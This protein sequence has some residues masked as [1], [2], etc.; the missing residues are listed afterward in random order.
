MTIEDSAFCLPLVPL[1]YTQYRFHCLFLNPSR[2]IFSC[3]NVVICC[4]VLSGG[5]V[6]GAP[7][8]GYNAV[9]AG[10]LSPGAGGQPG[11]TASPRKRKPLNR[12]KVTTINTNTVTKQ[13]KL[14]AV[15][16]AKIA[17][18]HHSVLTGDNL[19]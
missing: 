18:S 2:A 6:G 15:V 16:Q 5:I 9:T 7:P 17:S 12:K 1:I 4:V 19:W 13:S 10:G 14:F 8:Q 11:S 3:C